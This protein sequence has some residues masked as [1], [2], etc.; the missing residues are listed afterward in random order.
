MAEVCKGCTSPCDEADLPTDI[1]DLK[2]KVKE[3]QEQ[4]SNLKQKLSTLERPL[5]RVQS[6]QH[7]KPEHRKLRSEDWF[8]NDSNPELNV[9]YLDRYLNYGLTREEI[10]SRKPIIGIAQ[11]GS[12]LSPC[13]RYHQQTAKRVRDGIIASGGIPIEFPCHPIQESS[14][15]PTATLDRNLSYLTLVEILHS[16]PLD[17]VVLLTGCDK[18]TPAA[19]MAAATVNIPSIVLNVGPMLNGSIRNELIGT[20][21]ILWRARELKAEGAINDEEFADMVTAGTPSAGHCNTMGTASSMNALAEALGMAL[22]G[23]AA[24]PAAYRERLQCA[25]R[26][27]KR[28]VT[29]VYEDLKPSDIMTREA[30]ENA[31]VVNTAIGGSSNCPIHLVAI[32]R[33]VGVQLDMDDWDRIGYSIPL[34]ANVQPAGEMLCEDYY[35]AGGLPAVMAE[36]LEAKKLHADALTCT[37]R[38]IGESVRGQFSWNREVIRPYDQ[39]LKQNAGFMHLKGT[40]FDS[41]IMKT[42]VISDE[43]RKA[44]LEDPKHPN[45]WESKVRV[46]DGPEDYNANLDDEGG[47][48]PQE[49]PALVMRGTGAIGY[50]GAAEVVN[51]HAPVRLLKAGIRAVPCIGDGR[52]SGTSGSPSIL[53][54]S[55]EAAAG[56]NLALLCNGDTLRFDL[57]ARR[58]DLLLS[59]EEMESRRA[60]MAEKVA[61]L[62]VESQ[63]PWQEIF[64]NET[65]QLS[66]GMV[67]NCAVKYQKV[68]QRWPAPRHNH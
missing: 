26:T 63:T 32:A 14:R 59:E 65:S 15:R 61:Q 28:I 60:K 38:S 36:L 45:T 30:F 3:L 19:L 9:L 25:Y 58:V 18:T 12:D 37:G 46:F 31:I 52:Q 35:R 67:L 62:T 33:H 42:S 55:P 44:F 6:T 20:G 21:T 47:L 53:H 2:C 23:S 4:N 57:N 43:F 29:M 39:P 24:I 54:A 51:M 16:Y 13:N 66:D 41:G 48:D 68:A 50:P 5:E 56:G 34:L 7:K 10:S 49:R 1:E 22:P 17:G 8:S 64:R 40:L 27:G 11:S